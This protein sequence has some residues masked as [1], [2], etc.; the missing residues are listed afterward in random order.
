MNNDSQFENRLHRQP[1][2][3]IPSEWRAE[4]L[5]AARLA[6]ASVPTPHP[7]PDGLLATL[8]N[9]LA[10]L[11]VPQRAAWAGLATVWVVIIGLNLSAHDDSPRVQVSRAVN[12]ISPETLQAL[13]QQ[14]LLLAELMDRPETHPMDRPKSLPSG[15]RSQRWEASA[16]V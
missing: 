6:T 7:Q 15:P 2:K 5:E 4:I 10:P 16:T 13:Q 9:Y 12:A 14:R 3:P 8:R 11:L 1:V